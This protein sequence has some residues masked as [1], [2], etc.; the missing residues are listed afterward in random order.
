[1]S[2]IKNT[3]DKNIP[4][5]KIEDSWNYVFAT[6]EERKTHPTGKYKVPMLSNTRKEVLEYFSNYGECHVCGYKK[7]EDYLVIFTGRWCYPRP[8]AIYLDGKPLKMYHIPAYHYWDYTEKY[9]KKFSRACNLSRDD[10]IKIE[11]CNFVSYA[12]YGSLT[13]PDIIMNLP[14]YARSEAFERCIKKLGMT[15]ATIEFPREKYYN[16]I[17]WLG[18]NFLPGPKFPNNNFDR[19]QG[20]K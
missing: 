3:T 18:T 17:K 7:N 15:T 1:M 19:Y 12:D 6:A 4:N 9:N 13:Y 8:S 20:Y 16:F 5:G 2:K 10:N 11:R 14:S